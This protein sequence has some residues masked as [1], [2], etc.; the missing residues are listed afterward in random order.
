[1]LHQVH[2]G[3]Q[4]HLPQAQDAGPNDIIMVS[5]TS[6]H[7]YEWDIECIE[8]AKAVVETEI[9]PVDLERFT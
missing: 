5:T 3:P 7:A 4:L 9:L 6:Q 1:M 8:Y 2:D